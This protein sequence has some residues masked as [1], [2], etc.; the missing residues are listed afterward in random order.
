MNGLVNP[1]GLWKYPKGNFAPRF[2]FAYDLKGDGKTAIRGGYG[3]FYSRE[4]LGAFILMSGNPPFQQQ[5][6]IY[7]TLLSNPANGTIPGRHAGYAGLEQPQ[8][9]HALYGAV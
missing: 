4:I 7:N 8:P 9:G 6:L 3:L 1:A 5:A 2:S